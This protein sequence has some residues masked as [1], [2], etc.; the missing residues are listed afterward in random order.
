MRSFP[1]QST[2]SGSILTIEFSEEEILKTLRGLSSSSVGVGTESGSST[3][4]YFQ[5]QVSYLRGRYVIIKSL[6]ADTKCLLEL[7]NQHQGFEL[8]FKNHC[9]LL[10]RLNHPNLLKFFGFS[11]AKNPLE[12]GLVFEYLSGGTLYQRLFPSQPAADQGQLMTPPPLLS[13]Q[14]ISLAIDVAKAIAYQHGIHITAWTLDDL[15]EM[16]SNLSQDEADTQNNQNNAQVVYHKDIRSENIFLSGDL[17]G[18]LRNTTID[19]LVDEM[20]TE[21]A[22]VINYGYTGATNSPLCPFS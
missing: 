10:S 21:D 3:S 16:R 4:D 12:S 14:R 8:L 5:S 22:E 17:T 1:H 9:A 7:D 13:T 20:V 18:K 6:T 19:Q 15:V 2:S 11:L